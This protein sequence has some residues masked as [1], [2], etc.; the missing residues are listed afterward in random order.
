[1]DTLASLQAQGLILGVI[2]NA[3]HTGFVLR[4]LDRLGMLS[5]FRAVVVSADVGVRKPR[6]E[7]FFNTLTDLGVAPG[8]A[9]YIGDYYP[10]DMVGARAAGLCTVWL[11]DPDRPHEDLPADAIIARLP[12]LLPWLRQVSRE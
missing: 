10:Y 3:R 2:S 6:P 11:A 8:E 7:I 5:F 9:A 1:L 12:D 4:A